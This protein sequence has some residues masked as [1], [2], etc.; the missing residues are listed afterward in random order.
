MTAMAA[1]LILSIT[2]SVVLGL[3][4]RRMHLSANRKDHL[5]AVTAADAGLQYV[6]ARLELEPAWEAT[7]RT[8]DEPADAGPAGLYVISPVDPN[9]NPPPTVTILYNGTPT[10]VSIDEQVAA[11]TVGNKEVHIG[12]EEDPTDAGNPPRLRIHSNADYGD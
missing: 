10:A 1:A 11:L 6:L 9:Q 5:V 7:I 4:W 3:T 8:H 12:I 2:A